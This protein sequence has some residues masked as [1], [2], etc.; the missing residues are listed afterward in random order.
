MPDKKADSATPRIAVRRPTAIPTI[1]KK[2]PA[3]ESSGY[4]NLLESIYD[5][6]LIADQGGAIMD[7]N[8]RALHMFSSERGVLCRS[9]IT[10]WIHGADAA[11]VAKIRVNISNGKYTLIETY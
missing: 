4:R 5:G 7:G 2:P 6:V 10:D 8:S 11:L 9:N 1:K 3:D